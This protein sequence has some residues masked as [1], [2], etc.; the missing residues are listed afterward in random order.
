MK[1]IRL[2][3]LVAATLLTFT[4]CGGE[5]IPAV[6]PAKSKD[7][8]MSTD[9]DNISMKKEIDTDAD[10]AQYLIRGRSVGGVSFGYVD[11]RTGEYVIE[12][13]FSDVD[14]TFSEEG[15]AIVEN[16]GEEA[17][18]NTDGEFLF[19]FGSISDAKTYS[20]CLVVKTVDD[21]MLLYKNGRFVK[22]LETPEFNTDWTFVNTQ[23]WDANSKEGVTYKYDRFIVLRSDFEDG[24]S[25]HYI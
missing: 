13:S 17:V 9:A 3:S 25:S 15:W 5:K 21:S 20:D 12:P 2:V 16:D 22:E 18:I 8:A 4:A 19:D 23:I 1:R 10:L 6:G 14:N 24:D 11:V 7:A